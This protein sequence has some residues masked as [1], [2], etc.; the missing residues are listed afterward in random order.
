M[1][2]TEHL[3]QA[4]RSQVEFSGDVLRVLRVVDRGICSATTGICCKLRIPDKDS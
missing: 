4:A 3:E 1:F 2:S